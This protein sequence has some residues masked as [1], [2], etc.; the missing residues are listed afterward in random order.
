MATLEE[1]GES[2]S[3]QLRQ[4]VD[5]LV[6]AVEDET[7]DF[8]DIAS[9]ADAVAE[10]ADLVAEIYGELEQM[11]TRDPS[12]Q[13]RRKV[14]GAADE[15]GEKTKEDLLEQ[16]RELNVHGR[17]SMTK[18]ELAEAVEAEE[19]VT[20]EELLERAR[21]AEIEGRSSMDKDELRAALRDAGA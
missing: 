7:A 10:F 19:R 15:D 8:T 4:R 16:A 5:R 11:L 2:V 20:K 3:E 6:S 12:R 17:S 18:D 9:R 21:D 1:L 13:E 14:D